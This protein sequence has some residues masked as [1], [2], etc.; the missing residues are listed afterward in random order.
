MKSGDPPVAA[1]HVNEKRLISQ[2]KAGIRLWIKTARESNEDRMS[3]TLSK[4]VYS[5]VDSLPDVMKICWPEAKSQRMLTV[6]FDTNKSR[7]V[8]CPSIL[9]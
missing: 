4:Y 3:S 9:L 2:R 8:G 7:R 6:C 1:G 5:L